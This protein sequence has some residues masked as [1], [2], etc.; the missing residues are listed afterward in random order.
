MAALFRTEALKHA[1]PHPL[2]CSNKGVQDEEVVQVV[3]AA[4]SRLFVPHP[5]S[6]GASQ[7]NAYQAKPEKHEGRRARNPQRNRR[8]RTCASAAPAAQVV[9]KKMFRRVPLTTA[10]GTAEK[11]D[12]SDSG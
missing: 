8:R 4:V 5:R 3:V 1:P 9:G 6:G 7:H 12:S 2:S 10:A 11:N